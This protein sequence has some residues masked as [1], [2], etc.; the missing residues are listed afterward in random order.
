MTIDLRKISDVEELIK[1][2]A[3]VIEAVFGEKADQALLSANREYYVKHLCD[4]THM[5][6]V[7]EFNGIEA[8]CGAVCFYDELPSPDNLTGRCA[9]LMNIYVRPDYREK[10]IAKMLV[11]HLVNK[12]RDRHCGKIY[13]ET[14]DAGRSLYSAVGFDEMKDMMKL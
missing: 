3:E 14:T 7:A 1:W 4:D 8:G 10:G 12:A 5:A 11:R 6:F 13:L 9:Y 2:R